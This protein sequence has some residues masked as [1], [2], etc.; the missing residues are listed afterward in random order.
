MPLPKGANPQDVETAFQTYMVRVDQAVAVIDTTD[1]EFQS[2]RAV[3]SQVAQVLAASGHGMITYSKGLNSAPQI[4][5][6]EGVPAALVFRDFDS[7]GQDGAGDQ[8]VP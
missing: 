7:D 8:T 5:E 4:A 3:A 6:R 1:A 2:G